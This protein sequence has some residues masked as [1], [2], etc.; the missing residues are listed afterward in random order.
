M[1]LLVHVQFM[2]VDCR[3][4]AGTSKRIFSLLN[5]NQPLQQLRG[6][7]NAISCWAQRR[8][9]VAACDEEEDD[10][11]VDAGTG[12][13]KIKLVLHYI[14]DDEMAGYVSASMTAC[15]TVIVCPAHCH[16]FCCTRDVHSPRCRSRRAK[17][18]LP[19]LDRTRCVAVGKEVCIAPTDALLLADSL[20]RW[21]RRNTRGLGLEQGGADEAKQWG[22]V[23][24]CRKLSQGESRV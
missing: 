11:V 19:C 3:G 4:G 18:T 7:G 10:D 17:P 15:P 16:D 6:G 20:C 24:G 8:R 1:T 5:A 12:P 9:G 2:C 13:V 22:K 21:G 23:D 14:G